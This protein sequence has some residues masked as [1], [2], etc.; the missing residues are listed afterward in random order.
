MRILHTSDWHLGRTLYSKKD[1][2]LEHIAFFQWL[3]TTITE[4]SIEVLLVAGDVFDTVSPN[5]TSQKLY[6]DFLL[7]VKNTSCKHIIIVGGNHDSPSFLNAPKTILSALQIVVI[8]NATDTIEDEIIV[9]HSDNGEGGLIICGVPFLRERD[10]SRFVEGEIYTDRSKRI[11]ECIKLHYSEIGRLAEVK[12][13]ELGEKYRIIAT[14]HL[15]V[16]GGK[17]S[18]DDGVRET[19]IGSIEAVDSSIFPEKFEYVALGHYHLPSVIKEHI[20][21]CGSPIPMGFGEAKQTKYVYIIDFNPDRTIEKIEI[22]TFQ[23][24]ESISGDKNQIENRLNK[25]KESKNSVWTEIIYQG[26]E[27]LPDLTT[28][29][30]DQLFDSNIEVLKIQNKQFHQDLLT[31]GDVSASLDELNPIDVFSILLEKSDILEEQKEEL[32]TIYKEIVENIHL[33]D[34][35]Q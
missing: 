34:N 6:Y 27:I 29:I 3:L 24:L 10:I 23:Q 9:I 22:P 5:S 1:R 18:E 35:G 2:V 30:N 12:R 11:N 17:R 33:K 26:K 20:R 16:I 8:G 32:K 4:Q 15:S 28:W 7:N 13:I 21:Y 19:Y 14:G 31:Q 25:L